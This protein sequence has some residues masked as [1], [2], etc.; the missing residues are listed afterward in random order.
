[1]FGLAFSCAFGSFSESLFEMDYSGSV[2]VG[3]GGVIVV[4]GGY[5]YIGTIG[6]IGI[7]VIISNTISVLVVIPK[8]Y[9]PR[10][11]LAPFEIR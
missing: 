6:T 11:S 2:G 3:V 8:E 5:G 10:S 7:D 9:Q 4:I 1:M